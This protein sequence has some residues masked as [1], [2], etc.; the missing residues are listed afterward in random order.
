[1]RVVSWQQSHSFQGFLRAACVGD[2]LVFELLEDAISKELGRAE[3]FLDML[4]GPTV[5]G[6]PGGDHEAFGDGAKLVKDGAAPVRVPDVADGHEGVVDGLEEVLVDRHLGAREVG[7]LGLCRDEQEPTL[8][9]EALDNLGGLL[10]DEAANGAA[11]LSELHDR[12]VDEGV[13]LLNRLGYGLRRRGRR[14]RRRGGGVGALGQGECLLEVRDGLRQ[15][16]SRGRD[17]LE[18]SSGRLQPACPVSA[19]LGKGVGVGAGAGRASRQRVGWHHGVDSRQGKAPRR[20]KAAHLLI[21][22][23]RLCMLLLAAMLSFVKSQRGNRVLGKLRYNGRRRG[24]QN[25]G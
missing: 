23:V 21:R 13:K 1:M 24:V 14:G 6:D 2:V 9:S 4:I 11:E 5:D 3:I 20:L 10:G 25:R 17:I 16:D 18:P 15:L 19:C 7:L 12:L 8:F 22:V